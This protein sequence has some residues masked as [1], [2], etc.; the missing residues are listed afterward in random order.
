[1]SEFN[2]E[3]HKNHNDFLCSLKSVVLADPS[4]TDALYGLG[5]A[6]N[7]LN[8]NSQAE[9]HYLRVL[10]LDS[11]HQDA[12]LD[13][14]YLHYTL[15]NFTEV[16]KLLK[17]LPQSMLFCSRESVQ[18]GSMLLNSHI[19]LGHWKKA[20]ELFK[21]MLAQDSQKL[22]VDALNGLGNVTITYYGGTIISV[23]D[24]SEHVKCIGSSA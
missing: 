3:K 16:I 4:Q 6:Y 9:Q 10:N 19:K 1:M 13:L 24:S 15:P 23:I 17:G 11:L 20:E 21:I 2:V 5:L 14:A 22:Q 12:L 18:L 7:K 8:K